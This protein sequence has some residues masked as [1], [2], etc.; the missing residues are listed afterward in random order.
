ML[1][2][3]KRSGGSRIRPYVSHVAWLWAFPIVA[4]IMLLL[5]FGVRLEKPSRSTESE[6]HHQGKH[7]FVCGYPGFDL[8]TFTNKS[9]PFG[10]DYSN[11]G[12]IIP[13]SIRG[14]VLWPQRQ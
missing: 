3:I 2:V 11:L 9:R 5:D 7:S 4:L 13:I 8:Y 10:F 14:A 6:R 12:N 1:D